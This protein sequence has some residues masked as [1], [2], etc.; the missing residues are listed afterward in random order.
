M[1]KGDQILPTILIVEDD[2]A[3][4]EEVSTTLRNHGMN[5]VTT[6]DRAR[7][8]ILIKSLSPDLIL[9]NQRLGQLDMLPL[10]PGLRVLT[11]APVLIWTGNALEADR[12][13]ALE[14]G[15]DDF[16]LKSISG[17]ELV[18]RI[19]AHLRR[20]PLPDARSG[21]SET[22]VRPSGPRW[23]FSILERRLL[24]PDGAAVQLTASEFELLAALVGSA[25]QVL[26]RDVLTH[27]VLRR[28]WRVED[29][30]IDNLVLHLRRKLGRGGGQ[31]IGTVR[32]LGYIFT[33]FPEP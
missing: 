1:T 20:G 27:R 8:S 11:A 26:G 7:V 9:L 3:L 13:L 25:N 23:V 4:A 19:R 28:P 21:M 14:T 30:A 24:R 31:A 15:A 6:A 12:I 5:P 17:R 33:S 32:N 2:I 22:L 18:A 16:L 10:L 29:R